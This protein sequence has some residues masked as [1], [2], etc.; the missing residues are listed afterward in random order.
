MRFGP[1]P[2]NIS[3]SLRRFLLIGFTCI[4]AALFG[5]PV[6]TA[7]AVTLQEAVQQAILS[8]PEVQERWDALIASG[9]EQRR[10]KG[11]YYP[12][13][14]LRSRIGKQWFDT[15]AG[16]NSQLTPAEAS[17]ELTQLLY[18]G[19]A[20]RNEVEKF[21]HLRLARYF[22]LLSVSET[23]ALEA[24][25]AYL[26]LLRFRQLLQLA[27]DNYRLHL[28]IYR[29]V[30]E[31]V[32]AGVGRGVDLEQATG[33]LALADSNRITEATNLHDVR[34][35][36]LRLVGTIP[37]AEL[38]FGTEPPFSAALPESMSQALRLAFTDNPGF[39]AST[40]NLRAAEADYRIRKAANQPRL[41]F[42]ARH[43]IG[44]DRASINDQSEESAL[45]LILNYNLFRGGA[46]AATI[47]QFASLRNQA[48]DQQVRT[49]RDIRQSLDIA[50]N[51]FQRLERQLVHLERHKTAIANAR[52]AY[53]KQYDI[54]QR[55]LLDLL[56]TENEFFQANRAYTNAEYDILLA[57]LRTIAQTGH[58]LTG[59]GIR[60]KDLPLLENLRL[61]SQPIDPDT[62]CP[63]IEVLQPELEGHDFKATFTEP[64]INLEPPPSP[65]AAASKSPPGL[66]AEP[67]LILKKRLDIRFPTDLADIPAEYH[68][69]LRQL[70][71]VLKKFPETVIT[72]SGHTDSTGQ[73]P[74]NQQLSLRRAEAVR[75]RFIENHGI[76]PERILMTWL[77]SDRPIDTNA[78]EQG[79]MKNR[80]TEAQI[81][82]VIRDLSSL[83]RKSAVGPG[84][85]PNHLQ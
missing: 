23:I 73:D 81:S 17:L 42:R 76:D 31:R 6:A 77:S 19:F 53:L 5:E 55:T 72:L 7:R 32:E 78:T 58:L 22:E 70:A 57:Q 34:A 84:A 11:G 51:D 1:T 2:S 38:S 52:Q 3:P 79:R 9:Y 49:C 54:G 67:K 14:D 37:P 62:V 40:E 48:R 71:D 29:Q 47:S 27:E 61:D 25:R 8:N 46:D 28:K 66:G 82:L 16:G 39:L 35:R 10:A 85:V 65:P 83:V 26:D 69:D 36:Y 56:D 74:Y 12:R 24:S 64:P 80:R 30:K 20:T 15:S 50:F 43:E 45:E 60:Q 63:P 75:N 21:G 33:R 59:L 4:V 13:L 41:E 18:D 68:D 44:S